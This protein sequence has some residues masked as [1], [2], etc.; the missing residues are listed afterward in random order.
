MPF[1]VYRV[2]PDQKLEYI[3]RYEV[4]KDAKAVLRALQMDEH[5]PDV[6]MRMMFAPNES[7]A[8]R[9]LLAPR[10]DRILGDD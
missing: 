8:E 7:E 5:R 1:F 4:Y 9:L 3:D 10:D 2:F 6:L